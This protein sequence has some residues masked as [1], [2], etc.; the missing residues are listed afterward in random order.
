MC[1]LP[2]TLF[3]AFKQVTDNNEIQNIHRFVISDRLLTLT[4]TGH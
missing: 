2:F 3:D 1:T 4:I